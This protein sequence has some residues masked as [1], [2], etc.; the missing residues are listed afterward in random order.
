MNH[1]NVYISDISVKVELLKNRR[2]ASEYRQ[3]EIIQLKC[4]II[5][6]RIDDLID[7]RLNR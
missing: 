1:N 2:E 7:M 4:S 6:L 5:I 3:D